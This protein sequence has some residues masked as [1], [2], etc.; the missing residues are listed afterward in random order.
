L[1]ITF[2]T[3]AFPTE[4]VYGCL[5]PAPASRFLASGRG[6]TVLSLYASPIVRSS[7]AL[8]EFGTRN[9]IFPKHAN[10]LAV[11]AD[12]YKRIPLMVV[13]NTDHRICGQK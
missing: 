11:V 10:L 5:K 1:T 13:L 4:A 8:D 3:A 7:R 9:D 6:K 2:T 12:S